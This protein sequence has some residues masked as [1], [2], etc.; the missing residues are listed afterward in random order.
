MTELDRAIERLFPV[1]RPNAGALDVKF[2]F[3]E[4]ATAFALARQLN[5]GLD[6]LHDKAY[7]ITDVDGFLT[8]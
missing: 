6:V 5:V 3:K 8:E 1:D 4:G 7:E 2:F